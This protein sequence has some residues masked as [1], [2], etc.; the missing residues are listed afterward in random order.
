MQKRSVSIKTKL[1]TL[2]RLKSEWLKM[3]NQISMGKMNQKV[4]GNL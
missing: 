1:N 2:E 3:L 4:G